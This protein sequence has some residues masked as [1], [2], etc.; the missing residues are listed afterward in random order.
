METAEL[1]RIIDHTL[2]SPDATREDVLRHAAECVRHRLGCACVNPRHVETLAAALRGSG[3]RIAT[4]AGFPLGATF[5]AVKAREAE[6]AVRRG[7]H[8]VDMVISVGDLRAGENR[9]V[10]EEIR[11]VRSAVPG[12]VLKVIL[13]CGLLTDEEKRAGALLAVEAGA[14]FVKTST[15]FAAGGATEA[16]VRLLRAAVG[17]GCGVKAAGG[18][19]TRERALA[20]VAAG[21]SRIGT[22]AGPALVSERPLTP[23]G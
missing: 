17:P 4:V 9:V 11:L 10:L 3:V 23:G 22:S 16:D 12:A 18:I 20:L 1:A 14:D 13:E 7:A 6:E 21:A 15:G 8:E 2:L 19:R 5:P